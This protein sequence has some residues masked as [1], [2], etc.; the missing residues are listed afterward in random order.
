M[1]LQKKIRKF[2]AKREEWLASLKRNHNIS[3]IKD[4]ASILL[5]K[6]QALGFRPLLLL[7]KENKKLG[8]GHFKSEMMTPRCTLTKSSEM[9]LENIKGIYQI[10]VEGWTPYAPPTQSS[11]EA[12]CPT[13]SSD[14]AGCPTQSSG[15]AGCPTQSSDLRL[16]QIHKGAVLLSCGLQTTGLYVAQL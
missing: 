5:E 12:G 14:E 13:Q 15:E 7:A 10:M 2:D 1:R 4:E 16:P 8:P 9:C 3:S 11:G 6:L